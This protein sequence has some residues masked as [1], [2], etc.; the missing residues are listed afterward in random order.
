MKYL[1]FNEGV[2]DLRGLGGLSLSEKEVR[3]RV[4]RLAERTGEEIKWF[5]REVVS[6]LDIYLGDGW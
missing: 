6:V 3:R 4:E 5:E 2:E 1:V